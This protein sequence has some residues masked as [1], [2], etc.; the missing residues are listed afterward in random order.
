MDICLFNGTVQFLNPVGYAE[1]SHVP[2]SE[3]G[4]NYQH[5]HFT[6][7]LYGRNT[8][9]ES[10]ALVLNDWSFQV[11]VLLSPA[12]S[13]N[14]EQGLKSIR[15]LL[16]P[17]TLVSYK[18]GYCAFGYAGD[19]T[20]RTQRTF[21]VISLTT[22]S[23]TW[24]C[25]NALTD[26][27][28]QLCEMDTFTSGHR[29]VFMLQQLL[30]HLPLDSP[31]IAPCSWFSWVQIPATAVPLPGGIKLGTTMHEFH[32][33]WRDLRVLPPSLVIPKVR[34]CSFD[35]EVASPS[36]SFPTCDVSPVVTIGSVIWSQDACGFTGIVERTAY[37]YSL[38]PNIPAFEEFFDRS[39]PESEDT[40]T[41]KR[42]NSEQAMIEAWR[43]DVVIR[44]DIDVFTGYNIWGFDV[45]FLVERMKLLDTGSRFFR[46]GKLYRSWV[47]HT[48]ANDFSSS[49][50]GDQTMTLFD[51]P[52][53][54]EIDVY[55]VAKSKKFSDY[56]L[57]AVSNA[58]LDNLA[59]GD[60]P[61]DEI[62]PAHLRYE[63]ERLA[64]YCIRDCELPL[65]LMDKWG[66][67][68]ENI[69]VSQTKTTHTPTSGWI[70]DWTL[71]PDPWATLT[72]RASARTHISA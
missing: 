62:T 1:D 4:P 64:A 9:H 49:A 39:I 60:M 72:S 11:S 54:H 5:D 30:E 65:W 20:V 51:G 53:F 7:I 34:I 19:G 10:I 56:S 28:Y 18:Q 25:R 14:L 61:Y 27:G 29:E 41:L 68:A 17:R 15:A 36:A 38:K 57:K 59:K 16:P 6:Y 45:P 69:A 40:Y 58:T 24:K 21:A 33:S 55:I 47:A 50:R 67:I 26:A 43:D 42:Y 32:L 63:D 2:N 23:N 8:A 22:A 31:D 71:R 48:K 44:G 37:A 3:L 52:G 46:F 13:A 66:T 12:Q 70:L 35:I